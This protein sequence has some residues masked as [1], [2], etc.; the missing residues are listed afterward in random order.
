MHA[1]CIEISPR[2]LG[3]PA[4]VNDTG[5]LYTIPSKSF[6]TSRAVRCRLQSPTPSPSD[7]AGIAEQ[8][9]RA[10]LAARAL[11]EYPGVVPPDLGDGVSL[12]G[13]AIARWPDRSRGWKVGRIPP[14]QQA[15]YAE[16]RL[17]GPVFR[18]TCASPRPGDIVDCPVFE[19][20]FAAV[21]AEIVICVGRDAPPDKIEWTLD[22]AAELGR[23]A[24]HRHR[25]RGQP[26]RDINEL[27]AGRG[28]LGF[29]Q[30][31]G[32]RRRH[33]G[34]RLARAARGHCAELHR[35]RIRRRAASR[36]I[37]TARSPRWPSRSRKCARRGRPLQAG[38]VISTGMITGVHDIRPG[39]RSRH[40][41]ARPRR[42]RLP[43]GARHTAS[44]R[45]REDA[46]G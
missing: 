2:L 35:R 33:R 23:R 20:G 6:Q 25:D 7:V 9:V 46:C 43:R 45:P 29:R 17:V 5:F 11:P 26:A 15:R 30:Q 40:V 21:E 28:R 16:E 38:A 37:A 22:E 13:A 18:P 31:L 42:S 8:F 41:F 36:R 44:E 32:R 10:R 27:G 19:G 3:G 1:V 34:E 24:V 12:P 39:Q 14:A 4:I